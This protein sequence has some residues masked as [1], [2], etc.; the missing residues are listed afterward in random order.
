M[1]PFGEFANCNCLSGLL[2]DLA[3]A[4]WRWT[5]KKALYE[6]SQLPVTRIFNDR[7]QQWNIDTGLKTDV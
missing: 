4:I 3:R 1:L 5:E 2:N 6:S 7:S